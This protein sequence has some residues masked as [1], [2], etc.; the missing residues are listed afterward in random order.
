MLTP[1][2]NCWGQRLLHFGTAA[3]VLDGVMYRRN[4][5]LLPAGA[6]QAKCCR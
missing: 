5:T 2:L 1:G 6:A 4:A 3:L